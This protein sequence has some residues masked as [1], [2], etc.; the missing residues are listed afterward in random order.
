VAYADGCTGACATGGPQ[1]F[2]ALATISR[3][4]TGNT[5]YGAYDALVSGKHAKPKPKGGQ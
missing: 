4:A 3:Q 5:L 1:N 2:D